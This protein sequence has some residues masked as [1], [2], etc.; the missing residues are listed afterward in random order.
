M[1]QRIKSK[2]ARRARGFTYLWILVLAVST[3]LLIYFEQTSLL[4]I[5]ATLGVTILL[6]VVA[7]ADLGRSEL[8]SDTMQ[9]SDLRP[10]DAKSR[11]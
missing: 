2:K 9:M 11:N 3:F 7:L 1:S 10:P 4:Y 8:G 6:V 5:L